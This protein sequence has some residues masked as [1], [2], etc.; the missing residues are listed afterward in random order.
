MNKFAIEFVDNHRSDLASL[1]DLNSISRYLDRQNT[2][3][4]MVDYAEK[5]GFHRRNLMIQRSYK[6]IR[7]ILYQY[8]ILNAYENSK[9]VEYLNE[10]DPMI[11]KAIS[12]ID[13]NKAFPL[14]NGSTTDSKDLKSERGHKK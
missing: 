7:R 5:N 12:I 4:Q 8:I 6:L 9:S 3:E 14:I 2:V 1:E 11:L 10:I 13:E